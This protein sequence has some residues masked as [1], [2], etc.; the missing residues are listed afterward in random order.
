V[1]VTEAELAAAGVEDAIL[2]RALR[3]AP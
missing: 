2:G 3:L 1:I